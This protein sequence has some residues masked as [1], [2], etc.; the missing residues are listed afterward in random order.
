[1][2]LVGC[3]TSFD[4]LSC[5]QFE[6]CSVLLFS[7]WC[8]H[9]SCFFLFSLPSCVLALFLSYINRYF[10]G[11]ALSPTIYFAVEFTPWT[12]VRNAQGYSKGLFWAEKPSKV[13]MLWQAKLDFTD[14]LLFC[15]DGFPASCGFGTMGRNIDLTARE[16]WILSKKNHLPSNR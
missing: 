9:L 12:T 11:T 2:S 3:V 4:A 16:C 10:C 15:W 1:M 7:L 8:F 5:S 14:Y 13:G 6:G